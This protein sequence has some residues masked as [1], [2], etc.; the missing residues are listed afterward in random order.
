M[1]CCMIHDIIICRFPG[2]FDSPEFY[3]YW[4]AA[5]VGPFVYI[6]A[7]AH[8]ALWRQI[9]SIVGSVVSFLYIIY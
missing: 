6:C 8:A 1:H 5:V 9:S 7:V 2:I 3:A 4:A